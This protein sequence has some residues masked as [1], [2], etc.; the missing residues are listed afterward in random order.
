MLT[1]N[2]KVLQGF[3]YAF[4][5]IAGLLI[6][7]RIG[8]QFTYILARAALFLGIYVVVKFWRPAERASHFRNLQN[9]D[10][11]QKHGKVYFVL[12]RYV[13]L[14]GSV[15][16]VLLILPS[17]YIDDLGIWGFLSIALVIGL[18][19]VTTAILGSGEWNDCEREHRTMIA[20]EAGSV[21]RY[22][23]ARKN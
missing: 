2:H 3:G 14:R 13:V 5:M 20:W 17:L 6:G 10:E 12:T 8:P 11:H 19:I 15:L 22:I 9:W 21:E 16:F 1:L 23:A 7:S 4:S 18:I